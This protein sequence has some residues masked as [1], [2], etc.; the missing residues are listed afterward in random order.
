MAK[1]ENNAAMQSSQER[2]M[3]ETEERME[4]LRTVDSM[5]KKAMKKCMDTEIKPFIETELARLKDR[6]QA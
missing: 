6:D 4:L 3:R 2:S 1:K 5:V